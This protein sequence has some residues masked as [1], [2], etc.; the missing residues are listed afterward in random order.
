MRYQLL[1]IQTTDGYILGLQRVS[2]PSV[3]LR[4]RGSPILLI[5]GLLMVIVFVA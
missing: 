3:V 2:S 4:Q 1:Q 5:H